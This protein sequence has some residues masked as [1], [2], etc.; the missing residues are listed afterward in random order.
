MRPL[1]VAVLCLYLAGT[2]LFSTY[3]SRSQHNIR[4]YFITGRRMPWWAVMGSIV[5]TETSTVTFIS[6]PELAYGGDFTFLQLAIGSSAA[7]SSSPSSSFPPMFAG[8]CSPCTNC[9]AAALDPASDDSPL[10][11]S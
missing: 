9:S 5:A 3:F 11:F 4:D 7:D 10:R 2:V 1:D 6:V 8:S